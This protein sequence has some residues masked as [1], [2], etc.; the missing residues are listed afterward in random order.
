VQA[1]IT[2]DGELRFIST[3]SYQVITRGNPTTVEVI[4][5]PVR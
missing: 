4:V 2:V 5:D 1:R 3:R